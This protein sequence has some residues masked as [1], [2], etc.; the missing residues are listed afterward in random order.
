MIIVI[1][2]KKV[3]IWIQSEI[4]DLNWHM[5]QCMESR[6]NVINRLLPE[7]LQ[8]HTDDNPG[9]QNQYHQNLFIEIC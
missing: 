7:T 2:L 9:F 6:K 8:I 3:L 1:T 5:I 4:L